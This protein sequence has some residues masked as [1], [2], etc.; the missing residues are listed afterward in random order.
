M[1]GLSKQ[2]NKQSASCIRRSTN[3]IEDTGN[4]S[5]DFADDSSVQ[6][7]NCEDQVEKCYFCKKITIRRKFRK[8]FCRRIKNKKS[9]LSNIKIYATEL[10]DLE[11]LQQIADEMLTDTLLC[12]HGACHL[13]YFAKY[14]NF[15]KKPKTT[16]WA[17]T[18]DFNKIAREQLIKYIEEEV[19]VNLRAVSFK[20]LEQ[21]YIEC[22]Q[23]LYKLEQVN[24]TN[25]FTTNSLKT[26]IQNQLKNKIQLIHI[27]GHVYV[28]S[29]D[30][31]IESVEDEEI[32]EIIFQN[33]AKIF[34]LKYRAHILRIQKKNLPD[35]LDS[36][37]LDKGECDI[38][39]W[40]KIFWRTALGG[41]RMEYRT[42]E[43]LE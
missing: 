22:L 41:F 24:C 18:L 37:A 21:C 19:L 2:L 30:I 7:F 33:E 27:S 3:V 15:I 43:R 1:I 6:S 39:N 11:M 31:D 5:E 32:Q 25:M 8:I 9:F 23:D 42:S 34:A 16:D 20:V 14:Q 13:A 26:F 35:Y 29:A 38:P 17:T 28:M 40:L 10:N 12:Y 4:V 36:N